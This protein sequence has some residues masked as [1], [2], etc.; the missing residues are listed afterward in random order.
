MS[1]DFAAG[2]QCRRLYP[3]SVVAPGL[4]VTADASVERSGMAI[5]VR[6]RPIRRTGWSIAASVMHICARFA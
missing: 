3:F 5:G 1:A 4:I 2:A 6:K